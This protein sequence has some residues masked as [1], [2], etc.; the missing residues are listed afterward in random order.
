MEID[1]N[2]REVTY[3][4][5][6]R[7]T[8]S[9]YYPFWNNVNGDNNLVAVKVIENFNTYIEELQNKRLLRRDKKYGNNKTKTIDTRRK[10]CKGY[11]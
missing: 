7:N 10:S 6:D 9:S 1:L 5:I 8:Q 2:E 3:D 11:V 4:V